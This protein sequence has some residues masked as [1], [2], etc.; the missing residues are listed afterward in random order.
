MTGEF[1]GFVQ[2]GSASSNFIMGFMDSDFN[3]LSCKTYPTNGSSKFEQVYPIGNDEYMIF[4]SSRATNFSNYPFN[5]VAGENAW[6]SQD[7]GN[8]IFGIIGTVKDYAPV[9]IGKSDIVV[10]LSDPDINKPGVLDN[11]LITGEK[12]GTAKSEYAIKV[13]DSKDSENNYLGDK[14][15]YQR[16]N[17]NYLNPKLPID[18]EALGFDTTNY[19]PQEVSYFVSDSQKQISSMKRWINRVDEY[20]AYDDKAALGARNFDINIKDVEQLVIDSDENNQNNVINKGKVRAWKFDSTIEET[21][22]LTKVA[23]NQDQLSVIKNAREQY[24]LLADNPDKSSVLKPYPLK[25]TYTYDSGKTLVRDIN[26][27]VTDD[28]TTVTPQKIMYAYDYSLGTPIENALETPLKAYQHSKVTVYDYKTANI[29]GNAGKLMGLS[30][31]SQELADLKVELL[32]KK[33]PLTFTFTDAVSVISNE[34]EVSLR[35]EKQDIT[36]NFTD[37]EG[38]ELNSP[39]VIK[40]EIIGSKYNLTTNQTVQDLVDSII[41]TWYEVQRP[42]KETEIE[43]EKTGAEVSYVFKGLIGFKSVTGKM[44]FEKGYIYPFSQ[45]LEYKSSEDFL[46]KILDNRGTSAPSQ[47]YQRGQ[48]SVNATLTVPFT[49]KGAIVNKILT[50]AELVYN[51]GTGDHVIDSSGISV[52][53]STTKT[54]ER[55]FTIKLDEHGDLSSKGLSLRI[56]TGT[57]LELG[58]YD[59]EITWDLIQGP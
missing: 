5:G 4:G 56:P 13:Y 14:W 45:T 28:K 33:M 42:Q 44:T 36:V 10:D 20:T 50:D 37:E 51:D 34:I 59:A 7:T 31:D 32:I 21:Y 24:D 18:W 46:I 41:D 40:G 30:V 15:L 26:V 38:E 55:N 54:N 29:L 19:G 53:G 25:F 11:W 58:K 12:K 27:F 1:Q 47:N 16:I 3:I 48:F 49:N 22:D 35:P 23:V 43:V 17:R 52:Y 2:E 9:I 8:L 39:L 6:L 57:G